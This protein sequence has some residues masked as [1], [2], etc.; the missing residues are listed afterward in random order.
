MRERGKALWKERA[1]VREIVERETLE[2]SHARRDS[3]LLLLGVLS[4]ERVSINFDQGKKVS[5]T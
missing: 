4:G 3:A 5:G 2:V 1:T